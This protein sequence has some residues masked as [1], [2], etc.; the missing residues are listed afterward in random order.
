[1]NHSNNQSEPSEARQGCTVGYISTVLGMTPGH[2]AIFMKA[3]PHSSARSANALNLHG[4]AA[5][6]TSG[7][8]THLSSRELA[9]L[10]LC[11]RAHRH[12]RA[13]GT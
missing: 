11:T 1:M 7:T 13:G 3:T 5:F 2:K 9:L 4:P 6:A 8:Q 12:S 10:L